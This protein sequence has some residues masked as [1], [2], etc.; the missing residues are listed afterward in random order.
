MNRAILLLGGNIG[1]TEYYLQK[2]AEFLKNRSCTIL[3][4]SK[5][6]ETE[7]WGV[8]N[9]QNFLNKAF[10]IETELSPKAL[11]QAC[12]KTELQLG[13]IR[14]ER[15]GARTIDIDIIFYNDLIIETETLTIPHPRF[16][17]R[18]FVL[19]PL[20]DLIPGYTCPIN[21]KTI[22]Y[23]K[24][25]SLDQLMVKENSSKYSVSSVT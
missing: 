23:L 2:S 18:N 11:L 4:T 22:Q 15:W 7:A 19:W 25:N 9:Q 6:Y 16:H 21:Q 8:E 12:L 24:E 3:Q 14:K 1:D 5:T 10:L 20:N 17:L 13:R